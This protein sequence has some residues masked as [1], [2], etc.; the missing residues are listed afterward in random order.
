MHKNKSLTVVSL[1][2]TERKHSKSEKVRILKADRSI[3]QR[4]IS[5]YEDGRIVNLDGIICNELLSIPI[6]LTEINGDLRIGSNSLR[7]ANSRIILP[8][9]TQLNSVTMQ[10]S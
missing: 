10:T 5:A 3:L 1:Y 4:L 6:A 2:D 7:S 9:N 8:S